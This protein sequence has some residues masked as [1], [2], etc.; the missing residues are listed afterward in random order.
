MGVCEVDFA[1]KLWAIPAERMKTED[2]PDGSRFE[3]PL[4]DRA[5]AILKA[6]IISEHAPTLNR[7]SKKVTF[8]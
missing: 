4:C 1:E 5:I 7:T 6:V 8:R 2:D 3:V